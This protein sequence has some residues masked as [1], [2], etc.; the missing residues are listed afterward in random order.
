MSKHGEINDVPGIFANGSTMYTE[1]KAYHVWKNMFYRLEDKEVDPRW[2]Y[3]SNFIADLPLIE[4]F[5]AW[6]KDTQKEL[7]SKKYVLAMKDGT[8][9]N[10]YRADTVIFTLNERAVRHRTQK[11]PF[12]SVYEN[13]PEYR[14]SGIGINDAFGQAGAE[15]HSFYLIWKSM[16]DAVEEN[17]AT[18]SQEWLRLSVFLE[19]LPKIPGCHLLVEETPTTV[20]LDF[21]DLNKKHYSLST[22]K[23]IDRPSA[24]L[25]RWQH[26]GKAVP[27]KVEHYKTGKV[28]NFSSATEA[29]KFL[30]I[31]RD[32]IL[33]ALDTHKQLGDYL[34]SLGEGGKEREEREYPERRGRTAAVTVRQPDGKE[35]EFES[36]LE[37]A[38]VLHFSKYKF[39]DMLRGK[40]PNP[41]KEGWFIFRNQPKREYARMKD[42]A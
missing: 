7:T 35:L 8:S 13:N 27:L 1:Q 16:L 29:E 23:F 15:R 22:V 19:D 3:L 12:G 32:R 34:I 30:R 42:R 38:Q 40:S 11:V 37:A 33:E 31:S 25:R 28:L 5:E 14:V 24:L 18:I 21:I 6:D 17:R 20:Q 2:Y 36:I 39:A 9:C 4:G 10:I 41:D 26:T